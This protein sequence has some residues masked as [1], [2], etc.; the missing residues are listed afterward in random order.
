M[1]DGA[2]RWLTGW[3]VVIGSVVGLGRVYAGE[4]PTLN[5][6]VHTHDL[7]RHLVHARI[8]IP[9]KPGKLALWYPKWVPGTHSPCGPVENIAGLRVETRD[10]KPIPWRRDESDVYRIECEVPVGV[11]LVVVKLDVICDKPAVE[12]AGYLTYG[13]GSIAIINWATCLV[14][15]EGP[16]A[17]EI[18]VDA[19]LNLPP[20]WEFASAL[21]TQRATTGGMGGIGGP[22]FISGRAVEFRRVSLTELV[23]N[24]VIAAE[25]VRDIPL[26]TGPYP[27]AYLSLAS[28]SASALQISPQTIGIYSRVVK[29]AG[30]LFG[31][32]H[33]PSFHFLVTCSDE[34]GYLGLEHLACSINGLRERDLVEPGHLRGWPGMLLP[35]EYIHS[36][37]GK[38]RRP[39]GMC[40]PNF[41]TPQKTRLLWVYEGLTSY[42]DGI[43]MVRSGMID[44]AEYRRTLTWTINSLMHREGRRWRSLEDTA[45]SSPLLRAGST[46]WRELRRGQDYYAE[47]SLIWLEADAIIREKS[48][49]KRSLDDFCRKFLGM[50]PTSAQVVPYELAD[51]V[52]ALTEVCDFDWE[53]FLR[54]RTE[55][56][57]DALPLDVV[58]RCG[59]RISYTNRAPSAASRISRSGA[60]V[61]ALDSLGLSFDGEGKITDVVPGMIGDKAG[62]G[63]GMKVIGVNGKTFSGQRLHDALAD[64]VKKRKIEL[65]VV[66]GDQFRTIV[67][68]YA[69]GPRYLELV[70]DSS[71]PDLLAA[72][73]KPVAAATPAAKPAE[74]MV[75]PPP[76]G[77]VCYQARR[78]IKID[79]RL[80]DRDWEFAPWTDDFVDIEGDIRPRPRFRTRVKMMWDNQY[81]YVGALLDEPHVWGTLTKHDSVIFQDNDF[82]IFIDP[83]GDNHEYYE[84][85]INALNTEW[86][87]FLKKAYRDGG[88][89][90][91]EWEI[92]GLKTGVHVSGTLNNSGDK[93]TG[94]SVEFAIPWA[95]LAEYAHRPAPPRDGDQWRVNFSRVE[96]RHELSDGQYAKVPNI[97]ED[98]WVWSP[99]GVIDMH[100][101]ERWGYVQFSEGPPGQTA[102]RPDPAGPIRDRLMQ[103]YNAQTAFHKRTKRW[104]TTLDELKLPDLAGM[105][106]HQISLR[107]SA[108]GYLA[109]ITFTPAGGKGQTWTIQH[110]SRIR[111]ADQPAQ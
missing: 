38:F 99:Q 93:D 15:P 60:S 5:L 6:V 67:L 10:G 39:A 88:P 90:V 96:W 22:M 3:A 24:P 31:T 34:L 11:G 82:E 48:G 83:D 94:W 75:L 9:C 37:C 68:D 78:P 62:L 32:C 25:H 73:M 30:A 95:V 74:A 26:E 41:H 87:L 40:T 89:A 86:D 2:R 55:K 81:F 45:V 59:Y 19:T 50:G 12:A 72:I 108:D 66:A 28:E 77:Y 97:R 36:W 92:P 17:D 54:D 109:S 76:K 43:L 4:G 110:D 57:L 80:D 20:R 98:N 44:L 1:A 61:A 33:Y 69:D 103:I 7:P 21:E 16:S 35:H 13:T 42:L 27:P 107:P 71:R 58:Q 18:R 56:P 106:A 23:D 111:R 65:L 105:P 52:K 91:N 63:P 101:P 29:E 51:V 49:G 64:S 79:G 84:L 100:R 14:Y 102:Y 46:D 85:E 8:E 70:R 104:A 47:G 53:R